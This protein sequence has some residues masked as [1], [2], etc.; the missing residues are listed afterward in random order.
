[1]DH[2]SVVGFNGPVGLKKSVVHLCPQ[3][4]SSSLQGI[5]AGGNPPA[6]IQSFYSVEHSRELAHSNEGDIADILCLAG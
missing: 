6:P 1:M 3:G 4:K 2:Y 5:N